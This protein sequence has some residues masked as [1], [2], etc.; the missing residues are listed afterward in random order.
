MEQPQ[1]RGQWL[2][3]ARLD[4]VMSIMT[5]VYPDDE[6]LSLLLNQVCS[7][8]CPLR[9]PLPHHPSIPYVNGHS[10][11]CIKLALPDCPVDHRCAS[12]PTAAECEQVPQHGQLQGVGVCDA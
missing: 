1:Q 10:L 2:V 6:N 12:F 7:P 3:S 8:A 9:L 11:C 5:P 4:G